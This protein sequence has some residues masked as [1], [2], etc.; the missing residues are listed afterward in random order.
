MHPA[1]VLAGAGL[2]GL[3]VGSFLTVVAHRVPAG[4]SIV[5]PGS[6]CPACRTPIRPVDNVPVVSYLVR[7]GRCRACAAPIPVR[8]LLVEVATG[9]LFVAVADRVPGTFALGAYLV[10]AAA[11]VVLCVIDLEQMRL[12]T[13]IVV[14]AAALGVPLLAAASAGGHDWGAV[15]RAAV[16]AAVC[17]AVF[18]AVFVAV[19]RGIGLGDVRLAALCGGYL[20][21]LGYRQAVVGFLVALLAAGLVAVG[22]LVLGRVRRGARLPFGPF[23][24][25]GALVAVL[26][27]ADL[28]RWWLGPH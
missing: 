7:R 3:V 17:G 1:A 6:R 22:L 20:G 27:G 15:A 21:W 16:A 28:A 9:G 4:E 8:Y 26:W 23:L 5:R 2:L 11:L 24:G 18:L 13:P 14:A 19:P 10:L 12:P 25:A